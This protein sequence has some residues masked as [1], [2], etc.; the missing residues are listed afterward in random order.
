MQI[1]A[2]LCSQTALAIENN[3]LRQVLYRK[4]DKFAAI[5]ELTRA[6][7]PIQN[8]QTL[9]RKI[10]DESAGL[11]RAEQ[12][13]L[14]LVD[15]ETDELLL[16]AKMGAVENL[17]VRL[18]IHR[19]EGIAGKVAEFGE[20]MLVE[21]LEHDQRIRQKNRMNYKTRSF[22]SVPLKIDDRVIGVINLSD[23]TTGEVFNEEDLKLI[24]AFATHAA[25][26]MDR[27]VFLNQT[28]EL[29]KLT[30]TDHLTGLASR[31]YFFERLKV[32]LARSERH[33]HHFSLLMLDV[34]DFKH[35][36][37]TLGHQFGDKVLKDMAATIVNTIRSM[38][39][40]S[41]YGGDE[42]I[43][44]LPE[45]DEALAIDIAER[46][47]ANVEKKR[48]GS[49][50]DVDHGGQDAI[51]ASIGI[52]CYP[53][54]GSTIEHLLIN[55]DAALYRAKNSGKNRMAVFHNT[56]KQQETSAQ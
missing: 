34:D 38:D 29:K 3:H 56:H 14:M 30:I 1:V 13:S 43:I 25:I 20:A 51:T 10:L 23:K 4:F 18:R 35:C 36:N 54:H 46:M 48:A 45:T 6:I 44:I 2:A 21:D 31:R 47:R 19:G 27:N 28:E 53:E 5:S 50:K 8:Y 37:D 17:T 42:F 52:A 32:E 33:G 16:S 9:L 24:Q 11:L 22:V 15:H 40:A 55:V 39:I 12:G 26:V 7:T 41:R 49:S